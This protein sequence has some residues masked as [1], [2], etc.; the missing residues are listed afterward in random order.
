MVLQNFVMAGLLRRVGITA[1]VDFIL[2]PRDFILR[3]RFIEVLFG[4]LPHLLNVL[5]HHFLEEL[6]VV[7]AQIWVG[8]NRQG[9]SIELTFHHEPFF[10]FLVLLIEDPLTLL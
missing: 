2:S 10:P 9:M 5:L 6:S 7:T 8:L 1:V 3:T 4:V